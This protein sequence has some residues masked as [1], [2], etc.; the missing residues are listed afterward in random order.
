MRPI[1]ELN[2][3]PPRLIF[4]KTGNAPEDLAATWREAPRLERIIYDTLDE[5][6]FE[7][8][9]AVYAAGFPAIIQRVASAHRIELQAFSLL[10]R[11]LI[12]QIDDYTRRLKSTAIAKAILPFEV[13]VFGT[14]WEHIDTTGAKARFHGPVDYARVEAEFC[15]ATASL[16]MNPNIALSAHDRFFTALGA[17]IMP[18]TDRNPYIAETFPEL[19]PYTF[20]FT[21]GSITAAIEHVV[22]DPETALATARAARARTRPAAWV[23]KAAAEVL[24]VMQSASFLNTVPKAT[25]LFF[26]P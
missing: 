3:A 21:P 16:T 6:Q 24:E 22:G 8:T 1:E 13:D 19:L 12:V 4:A 14:A 25:Q 17:G 20:D 18:V 10:S 9:G 2:G 11:F 15:A 26:V 7:K 5:L 23:D